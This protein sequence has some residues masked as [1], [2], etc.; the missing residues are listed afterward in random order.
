[1]LSSDIEIILPF[2]AKSEGFSKIVYKCPAN[3]D[4]IGYGRN[5]ETN[6]LS[7]DELKSIGATKNTPKKEY[8]VSEEIAKI[9]LEQELEKVKKVLQRELIFFDELDDVRRAILID[10]AYNM[11]VKTLLTFKNTLASIKEGD[12]EKASINMQQSNWYKQVGNRS[13]KLCEAM[14]SGKLEI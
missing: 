9:W 10:M 11:G 5:I 7:K 13:K 8:K 6:P 4:T 2:T 3:Y 1:M 14:K 12:F